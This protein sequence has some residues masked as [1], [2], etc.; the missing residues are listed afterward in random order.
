LTLKQKTIKGVSWS[1]AGNIIQ[2]ITSFIIGI[3]LARLLSP[4][5][6][7][8]I[9]MANV[10]IFV[11]YVFIDSGFSTALI[12]KQS[13]TSKDY[14]TVF[15]INL[16][17]SLFFFL[18]LFSSANIISKFYNEPELIRVIKLLSFLIILYAFS[19]VQKSIITRQMN[20]KLI[21][22][23]NI[24][25]QVSSGLIGILLAYKGFGVYSLVWKTLLNQLFINVQLWIFNKWYPTLEFSRSSLKEMFPFSSKLLI[26]GTINKVYE[27]LYSLTIGKFF[28]AREL[29][30]YTRA[31]QFA[32]LPSQ[33]ISGAIMN[34]SFPVFSQIQND[35]PR[36]K[37]IAKKILKATMF[38]NITAMLGLASISQQLI[39]TL[40]GTKWID[41]VP[42]LQLLCFVGVLYPLHPINLN[43]ITSL[44]RSDLFLRLEIIKKLLAVPVIVIGIFS[45]VKVMLYGLIVTSLIAIF[46]NSH[47][48]KRLIDYDIKE[49]FLDIL[50][51][52]LLG[53]FMSISVFIFGY[54]LKEK[55]NQTYILCIQVIAGI[56]LT[57]IISELFNLGTYIELKNIVLSRLFNR[58]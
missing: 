39:V 12:Q 50:P 7:G 51:S 27:Q 5:Q 10:F 40:I 2:N 11:T 6:Y 43:I 31:N 49:Q 25:S 23:I 18:L 56:A 57:I 16:F 15:F 28:S 32:N 52:L 29:G 36:M 13:C 14:S 30:L 53:L 38:V 22:L 24:S 33:S 20:F 8:V 35:P 58:H 21:N 55:L 46:I 1:L 17:I 34:V 42:Y 45:S 3:I 19:I 47:Y 9:G 48:T 4:S 37:Q 26:S 41:A 44:G 54:I